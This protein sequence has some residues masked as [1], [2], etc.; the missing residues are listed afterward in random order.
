MGETACTRAS[1]S[2]GIATIEGAGA[3]TR[4]GHGRGGHGIGGCGVLQIFVDVDVVL[5]GQV[6]SAPSAASSR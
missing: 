6:L 4:T 1:V 5:A 2:E 3:G